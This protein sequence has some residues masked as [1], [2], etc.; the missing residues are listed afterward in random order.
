MSHR[1]KAPIT[2][3]LMAIEQRERLHRAAHRMFVTSEEL[4]RQLIVWAVARSESVAL[5]G[6]DLKPVDVAIGPNEAASCVICGCTEERACD[7]QGVPCCWVGPRLC[8][9][10][11]PLHAVLQTEHGRQWARLVL[12]GP[13]PMG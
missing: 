2:V 12:H 8:S 3:D 4:C 9:G 1:R 6:C 7:V 5:Q 10:C 11:A 13:E